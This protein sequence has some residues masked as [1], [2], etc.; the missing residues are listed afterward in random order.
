M[1]VPEEKHPRKSSEFIASDSL[2]TLDDSDVE[3]DEEGYRKYPSYEKSGKVNVISENS[4][5]KLIW[6]LFEL[7]NG[8]SFMKMLI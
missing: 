1:A 3:V 7:Y 2:D 6:F 4:R 8:F 5:I